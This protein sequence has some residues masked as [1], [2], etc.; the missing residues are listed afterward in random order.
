M[1]LASCSDYRPL[2]GVSEDVL[3]K[4][5]SIA[6]KYLGMAY[7]WGGQS[8]WNEENGSV[9]CSGFVINV[10]KEACMN[11]GVLLPYDDTTSSE[12][13]HKYTI[14][15]NSPLPGDLIFMGDDGIVS[16][17]AIFRCFTEDDI[18][19]IDAYSVD[20]YV[21]IRRYSRDNDKIISFG[22]MKVVEAMSDA[23]G[24]YDETEK[25]AFK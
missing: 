18:E 9:D 19:F 5:P 3:Q 17:V 6:E 22:R 15:I 25:N 12:L 23:R 10:Y 20:G 21:K 7:E 16:H 2:L 13:Y 11:S 4:V 14:K 1:L 24:A 8:F